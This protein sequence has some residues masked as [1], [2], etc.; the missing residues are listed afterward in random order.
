MARFDHDPLRDYVMS[1]ERERRRAD[2]DAD[3]DAEFYRQHHA[4]KREDP[5]ASGGE[6]TW[7]DRILRRVRRAIGR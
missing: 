4:G 7:A 6:P 3:A 2:A 5:D 1:E